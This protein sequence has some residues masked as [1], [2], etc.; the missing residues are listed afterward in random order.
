MN[1]LSRRIFYIK[2]EILNSSGHSFLGRTQLEKFGVFLPLK[3][4]FVYLIF[5]ALLFR[6]NSMSLK[7]KGLNMKERNYLIKK[8]FNM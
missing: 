4:F 6:E 8:F 1:E 7:V 3:R 5:E 2:N